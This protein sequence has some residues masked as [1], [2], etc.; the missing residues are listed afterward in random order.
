MYVS[1]GTLDRGGG[2]STVDF[3]MSFDV[4]GADSELGVTVRRQG[5]AW[6][7]QAFNLRSVHIPTWEFLLV[8]TRKPPSKLQYSAPDRTN[9]PS[10]CVCLQIRGQALDNLGRNVDLAHLLPATSLCG[11]WSLLAWI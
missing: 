2:S 5:C 4:R 10:L 7:H 3:S 9:V 6:S 8:L 11:T 1:L